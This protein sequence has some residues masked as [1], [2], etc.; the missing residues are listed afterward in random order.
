MSFLTPLFWAGLGLL[1]VPIII[2]LTQ[3]QRSEVTAFPS[4]MFLRKIPFK[5]SNRRRIR[6]PL[7]FAL[8]CL[9]IALMVAAFARPFVAGPGAVAGDSARDVV[10]L[11]DNSASLRYDGRWDA[12]LDEA[13]SIAGGLAE[14]DRAALV[15]FNERAAEEMSLTGDLL[16]LGS[17]IDRLEPTD[18]GTRIEAGL[19]LAG[20]ILDQSERADREVVL[21]TDFQRTGWE[22]QG[23]SRLPDGVSLTPVSLAGD[24]DA[25][26]VVADARF[27]GGEGGRF[28]IVA[29]VANMGDEPVQD[30]PVS[31]ELS[32]RAV[33]T[34]PLDIGPRGA[35]TVSFDDV[36]LPEG[37]IRGRVSIPGDAL[38]LDDELRFMATAEPGLEVLIL[39]G[40][41][42]RTDRS[43][44]V[45]RALAIGD[46]PRVRPVRR[47]ATQLDPAWLVTASAIV[48]NDANVSDGG[49][50]TLLAE[51]VEAG[52]ALF[53]ALGANS[54][55]GQWAAPA[56]ALLGGQA[57]R[58]EDRTSTGGVR[59][60]SLDYDHPIFEV[61]STPR[62]GDF[63]EARFFRF[64]AFEPGDDARVLAR[65]E[66]GEP[67]LVEHVVGEG[68]V[69]VWMSTLDRFWNDLA[70]QPVFLPFIHR[71]LMHAT[72][73]REPQRWVS[74]GDLVEL[75]T[76]VGGGSA[77]GAEQALTKEWV[78]VTPEGD[79]APVEIADG[80]T[81]I[82]FDQTGFY[83][84]EELGASDE[85]LTVAVNAALP[86]SDLAPVAPERILSSVVGAGAGQPPTDGG[87]VPA[88]DEPARREL[89][90]F[91]LLAA[92]LV[93]VAESVIANRWTRR[94][95][96]SG[97][98]RST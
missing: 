48:L 60:S 63:S 88:E 52:G 97:L 30:L 54:D 3:R 43:L 47:P 92:A 95:P 37:Q 27:S 7:L 57:G 61:F 77:A 18:L 90:W 82:E 22:D 69:L 53:V 59:V 79:R 44:F 35:A 4:L 84:V 66:A 62:S 41:R 23:R 46:E 5:T 25:N 56:A 17:A 93:L 91:L 13:R 87:A 19:Q 24:G 32:G 67:A 94:R 68:R 2:H 1:A 76:L 31:L 36:P 14:G 80:P 65:F 58:V 83:Q 33:A 26:L 96:T 29:R 16:T 9:A 78:L 15:T 51:W 40:T 72:R 70:L 85:P 20:R 73:Y 71:S 98:A 81:W 55:P 45:E 89:W 49:R 8:R 10:I 34:R 75:G 50:A 38:A 12:A 28:R 64:R 39:E 42:G 11:I 86:E 6:H 74:A 21:I